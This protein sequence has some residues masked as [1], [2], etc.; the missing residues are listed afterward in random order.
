MIEA[1]RRSASRRGIMRLCH[2]TPSRNLVHIVTD[3]RGLLAS[4]HLKENEKA[5]FNPTDAARLDGYPDHVCCSIQYPNAWYFRKAREKDYLFRDWVVVLIKPQH[6]WT[7]GTKFC[8]R[9]AA[10]N[11][12]R[13][14]REG[15]EAFETLFAPA[16]VGAYGKTFART[17]SHP[18]WLPT[19]EQAEVLVPDRIA[20]EDVLGI[21][22]V[23]ESQAKREMAR[24]ELLN[25][26]LPRI[27]IAPMFFNAERLSTALRSGR[28]PEESD[29]HAGDDDA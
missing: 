8:P 19:D 7:S 16:V 23:N 9:N 10:A 25:E 21:A 22:V 5:V 13:D 28:V 27:V 4:T 6:L 17:A 14:V 3:P 2:F 11:W 29:Y 24:L 18:A 26:R 12:G 20:R 1:I 15:P